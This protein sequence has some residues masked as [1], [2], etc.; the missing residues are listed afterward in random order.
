MIIIVLQLLGDVE[1]FLSLGIDVQLAVNDP[2]LIGAVLNCVPDI[3]VAGYHTIALSLHLLCNIPELIPAVGTAA[4]SLCYCCGIVSAENVL[5][6]RTSVNE[7][8][9][10]CLIAQTYNFAV[11]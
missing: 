10:C 7:Y 9:A 4:D 3:T 11:S 5:S 8:A 2:A 1:E 6:Q